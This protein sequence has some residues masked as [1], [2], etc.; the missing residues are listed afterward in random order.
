MKTQFHIQEEQFPQ[1]LKLTVNNETYYFNNDLT[2][3]FDNRESL[4]VDIELIHTDDYIKTR[5]IFVRFFA[6]IIKFLLYYCI[7]S[8]I[9]YFADNDDGIHLYRGYKSFEPFIIKKSFSVNSPDG[10]TINI[11][12]TH[13]EYSRFLKKY[14]PP[15]IEIECEDIVNQ[16]E[17]AY[18]SSRILKRE[19]KEYNI[20]AFGILIILIFLL[21]LINYLVF[22][23]IIREI[24]ISSVNENIMGIIGM[25]FCSIVLLVLFVLV[26]IIIIKS[27]RFCKEVIKENS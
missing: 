15:S 12:Y 8:P 24:P 23:K 1:Y 21:N 25:S 7:L 14:T 2:V 9:I 26:I 5:K 10:K 20:P 3:E 18:F 27:C 16:S 6:F 11:K 22:A 19:W 13:C 4:D 17:E